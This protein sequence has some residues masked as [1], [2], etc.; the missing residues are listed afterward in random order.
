MYKTGDLGQWRRDGVIEYMGR[1]DRQ[2][3]LRGLRIELGEI[4]AALGHAEGAS[5]VAVQLFGGGTKDAKL[6]AYIEWSRG[7]EVTATDL[8]KML[9][10]TLPDYMVPQHFVSVEEMPMTTNGKLDRGALPPP[11]NAARL[12]VQPPK[13]D[14]G[15]YLAGIW[16]D[17]LGVQAISGTDNFFDLG[18]HSLSA[19]EV[20]ARV[21]RDTGVAIEPRAL[22]LETLDQVAGQLPLLAEGTGV[23]GQVREAKELSELQVSPP[24]PPQLGRR[25]ARITTQFI[26]KT[27]GR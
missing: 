5:Q 18:G 19:M 24:E 13:S 26:K 17:V 11:A 4:E 8:R 21:E 20:V 16:R 2:V 9:R 3:K 7:Q 22:L 1:T 23:S 15:S 6:V 12:D 27:M 25:L 14:E 10:K